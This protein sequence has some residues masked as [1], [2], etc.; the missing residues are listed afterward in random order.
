M[1]DSDLDRIMATIP[2][3]WCKV[4]DIVAAGVS[5]LDQYSSGP[6]NINNHAPQPCMR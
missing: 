6:D 1:C 4:L 3:M 5:I 2:D